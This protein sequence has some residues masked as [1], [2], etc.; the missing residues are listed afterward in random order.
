MNFWRPAAD[1]PLE[2]LREVQPSP[3]NVAPPD[4]AIETCA[5]KPRV[6]TLCIA[7]AQNARLPSAAHRSA[8]SLVIS[9]G[10]IERRKQLALKLVWIST[11]SLLIGGA[12]AWLIISQGG[13]EALGAIIPLMVV[14]GVH[15][16]TGPVAIFQAYR[17]HRLYKCSCVY[18]YFA[19]FLVGGHLLFPPEVFSYTII[20]ALLT[21]TPILFSLVISSLKTNE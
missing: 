18:Y 21:I 5:Q 16:F 10:E 15:L 6:L 13:P 7:Q 17:M 2:L 12:W 9:N 19:L 3:V 1:R 14:G 11:I 20:F 8:K 4:K